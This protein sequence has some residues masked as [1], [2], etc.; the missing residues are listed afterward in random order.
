[1]ESNRHEYS[2]KE[3]NRGVEL[4]TTCTS[5]GLVQSVQISLNNEN[6]K[7]VSTLNNFFIVFLITIKLGG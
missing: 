7:N 3:K 6:N 2:S 5:N 4:H 1:M